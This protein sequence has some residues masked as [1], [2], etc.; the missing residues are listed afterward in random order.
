[1][2]TATFTYNEAVFEKMAGAVKLAA[3]VDE[4]VGIACMT[5]EA[6]ILYDFV[7]YITPE[8]EQ[9]LKEAFG[10]Q[11]VKGALS[12]AGQALKGGAQ[13]AMGAVQSAA[14]NFGAAGAARRMAAAGQQHDVLQNLTKPSAL[15]AAPTAAAAQAAMP[16][17]RHGIDPRVASQS[18]Q[19]ARYNPSHVQQG[20]VSQDL[21]RSHADIMASSPRPVPAGQV[22]YNPMDISNKQ[23]GAAPPVMGPAQSGAAMGGAM[24]TPPPFRGLPPQRGIP[25]MG[26]GG[27]QVLPFRQPQAIPAMQQAA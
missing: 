2:T 3:M 13:K 20:L 7:D 19:A 4:L 12:G 22:R 8:H 14:Q 25:A 17:M 1:M 23:V 18:Y 26:G 15:K 6:A 27:G 11:D 9:M 21:A 5:K 24:H 16:A 10:W